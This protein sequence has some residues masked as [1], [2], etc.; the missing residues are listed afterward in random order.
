[1]NKIIKDDLS[2]NNSEN[3]NVG[4]F[5]KG[6]CISF[7]IFLVVLIPES[8]LY[9]IG[10]AL[11]FIPLTIISPF[12]LALKFSAPFLLLNFILYSVTNGKTKKGAK[13]GFLFTLIFFAILFGINLYMFTTQKEMYIQIKELNTL[14]NTNYSA[15]TEGDCSKLSDEFLSSQCFENLAK[16]NKNSS[17]CYKIRNATI[18]SSCLVY[19]SSDKKDISY[20]DQF[21]NELNKA[22]CVQNVAANTQNPE[23]CKVL[24]KTAYLDNCYYGAIKQLTDKT[25]IAKY[26][27]LMKQGSTHQKNCL[28]LIK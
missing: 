14:R 16:K 7:I 10:G 24:T 26:C 2:K 18:L 15:N 23:Y 8:L 5:L 19:F 22:M 11:G 17:L 20:C 21:T 6:I 4:S 9:I 12:F 3:N 13:W 25:I 28:K 27:S 1:M